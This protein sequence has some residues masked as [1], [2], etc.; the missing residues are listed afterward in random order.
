VLIGLD[1][2]GLAAARMLIE[3]DDGSLVMGEYGVL[4]FRPDGHPLLSVG[5]VPEQAVVQM[6]PRLA[7]SAAPLKWLNRV[8]RVAVG[9]AT[10]PTALVEHDMYAIRSR[11]AETV[12]GDHDGA[13][14]SHSRRRGRGA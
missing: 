3:T 7:T 9:R 1:G 14:S 8:R 11:A 10:M 2:I 13:K 5:R 12:K 6:T 4:D